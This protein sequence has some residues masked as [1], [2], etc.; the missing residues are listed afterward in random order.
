[1]SS[2]TPHNHLTQFQKILVLFTS[3]FLALSILFFRAYIAP[4]DSL[5]ELARRSIEPEIAFANGKPTLVEFYADWCEVCRE[6]APA[7]LSS[8]K[9]HS[10][11]INYVLLNVDNDRWIDLLE[12]YEVN[13]IP[14]INFFDEFG[15]LKTIAIGQRTFD[16]IE[17]V[18]FGLLEKTTIP[19][20]AGGKN[21]QISK[22]SINS[23]SKDKT[24]SNVKPRSHG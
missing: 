23:S 16:E 18:I 1:M 9:N 8:E 2:S 11:E 14:Q 4:S 15:T 5:D 24:T 13:G 6:M 10:K 19:Q 22:L 3:F 17:K 7:M 20:L 21:P 12:E